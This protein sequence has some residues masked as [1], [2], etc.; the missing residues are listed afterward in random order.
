MKW[1]PALGSVCKPSRAP[2]GQGGSGGSTRGSTRD[3]PEKYWSILRTGG[4]PPTQRSRCEQVCKH[5]LAIALAASC[6]RALAPVNTVPAATVDSRATASVSSGAAAV[7]ARHEPTAPTAPN[8]GEHPQCADAPKKPT[9]AL[10]TSEV[11][12]SRKSTRYCW[13]NEPVR[14]DCA[15]ALAY[16]VAPPSSSAGKAGAA[17]LAAAVVQV[18]GPGWEGI[19]V[20][21]EHPDRFELAVP[22]RVWDPRDLAV[23]RVQAWTAWDSS[24]GLSLDLEYQLELPVKTVGAV[25][26]PG[27]N[28]SPD[29]DDELESELMHL[30]VSNPYLAAPNLPH[31]QCESRWVSFSDS[32]FQ[33][34]KAVFAAPCA[35]WRM[36]QSE[37]WWE[38]N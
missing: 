25:D 32:R 28:H 23:S 20:L 11:G 13:K 16:S 2:R 12:S 38:S 17:V 3:R 21:A 1:S 14:F 19:F 22:L 35:L 7:E 9:C 29:T 26:R 15:E 8:S 34:L 36:R 6:T 27:T 33:S 31:A 37:E 24:A 30:P 5:T 4:A 10:T 18:H